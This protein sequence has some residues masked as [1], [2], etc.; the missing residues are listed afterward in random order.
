MGVLKKMTKS[1]YRE[2]EIRNFCIQ[3]LRFKKLLE[4]GRALLDLFADG[5]EK[6]AGEYIFDRHY[7]VSLIDGVVERLGMMIYDAGVLVPDR[8][9][10]LF[11]AYDDHKL[12]ARNL[13]D[14]R[15][16]DLP[17][18]AGADPAGADDPEYRLLSDALRWFYGTGAPADGTV[19]DF[20]KQTFSQ[21]MLGMTPDNALNRADL[22]ES[23]GLKV[24]DMDMYVI[25]LWKD[26][27]FLPDNKRATTDF[28]SIPFRHLL[29][30]ARDG[31]DG[32]RW[33]AAVSE[34]QV[35]LQSLRPGG[36]FRLETLASGYESSDFIFIF[37]DSPA[38]LKG[39]LPKGFHV[40][41]AHDGQFAWSLDIPAETMGDTLRHIGR[42]IFDESVWRT[43]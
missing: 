3:T 18:G 39:I 14:G 6:V 23:S 29:P 27:R 12:A 35:S 36:R 26:G 41:S 11:A 7:V 25:D 40:E 38:V 15:G 42:R 10:Y 1:G 20:I 37:T 24:T 34:H 31:R 9:E 5:R 17:A 8:G 30:A 22:F 13:I 19:M 16:I 4:N 32:A 21:V 43:P 28:N 33:V 2:T